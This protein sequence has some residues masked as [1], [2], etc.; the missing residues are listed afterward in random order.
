MPYALRKAPRQDK[1]WVITKATGK[2]H[3]MMPLPRADAEAQMRAI[4]ASTGTE[5]SQ[6][7]KKRKSKMRGGDL[8]DDFRRALDPNRNGL[9]ES[10]RRTGEVLGNAFDP[11]KNGL[12]KAV[13]SAVDA[14]KNVNWNEVGS[15]I[16][17][18]LDPSKNGVSAAF[19]KFG[20]DAKRAFQDLGNKIKESAQRDKAL[21]DAAFAPLANE[22][23]NPN[24]ALS[25][26]VKSV[27][28]PLTPDEWKKKFE[29][30]ET[31]FTLLSVLVTAAASVV[32]AGTAGPGAFAAMQAL[33]LIHI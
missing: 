33:S 24:S 12:A 19:D 15:K 32:S 4:Y 23:N 27:G 8:G 18:G 26:F 5:P 17:D 7:I 25:S 9:N 22:F 30:P 16:G 20:G 28:I 2:H 10:L 11:N 13:N 29:D 14:I 6:Q 3:S 31:Y 21:L 1:Y